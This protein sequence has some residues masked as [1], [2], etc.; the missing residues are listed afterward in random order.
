MRV[1]CAI[2]LLLMVHVLVHPIVHGLSE[3]LAP[4]QVSPATRAGDIGATSSSLDS[5]D[6]CRAGHKIMLWARLP[7]T[8][9]LNPQWIPIRLQAASYA[10]LRVDRRLPARAPPS[11]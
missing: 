3:V 5:C 2:L 6:L 11:L 1:R 4:A 8:E 9:R 7:E 10:S